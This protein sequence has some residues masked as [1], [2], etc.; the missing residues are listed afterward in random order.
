MAPIPIM[1]TLVIGRWPDFGRAD[2]FRRTPD[3]TD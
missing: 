2:D 1:T 3:L